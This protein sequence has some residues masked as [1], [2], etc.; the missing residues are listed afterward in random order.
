MQAV[1]DIDRLAGADPA[2]DAIGQLTAMEDLARVKAAIKRL[3]AAC[4]QVLP[5]KRFARVW[6]YI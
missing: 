4:R 5:G 1:A 3:P 2:P 6:S